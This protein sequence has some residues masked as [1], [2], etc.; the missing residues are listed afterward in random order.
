MALSVRNTF[1]RK[2]RVV[3]TL[4]TLALGGAMFMMVMSVRT[5]FDTTIDAMLSDF[6]GDALVW[7]EMSYRTAR[8]TEVA[9][10]VPGVTRAEVWMRYWG[11]LPTEGGEQ[12]VL[13]MGVPPDSGILNP[14]VVDGR[15]LQAEDD[16]ALMMNQKLAQEEGIRVGDEITVRVLEEDVTWTVVGLFL[17]ADDGQRNCLVPIDVLADEVGS[18]N[19]GRWAAVSAEEHGP[20][21]RRQLVRDLRETYRA[22]GIKTSWFQTADDMREEN[23][24]GFEIVMFLLLGMAA[25]TAVV[26]G[27]GMASTMS[28]NV[29]ERRREIGVMRATGAGSVAIAAIFVVEGVLL[30]VLSCLFAVPIS[31]PSSRLFSD[32]VGDALF[33]L[34]FDFVYSIGGVGL[35]LLIV[36]I[37]SALASLWPALRATRVSVREAL[38]YE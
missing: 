16:H 8:L 27:I 14:R 6:G 3:L 12:Y 10:S 11:P 38:A 22:H 7:F 35:W 32:V 26:G 1:R 9:E 17:S 21:A 23:L 24:G 36:V 29:V 33:S 25:L 15:M 2:A 31:V 5:S 30:G 28:I 20:E 19:R 34:P 13:L 37:L 4:L 18:P